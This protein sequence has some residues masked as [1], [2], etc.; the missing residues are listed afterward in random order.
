MIHLRL[1]TEYS[2]R[3]AYGRPA[4]VL[5]ALD[6]DERAAA[7]IG[8][9]GTWGHVA[10]WKACRKAEVKPL[11]G[12]EVLVVPDPELRGKEGRQTGPM[13]ALLARNATG[14]REL[15]RTMTWAHNQGFF[16][17]PRLSYD[18]INRLSTG[19]IIVLSGHNA[20]IGA[21]DRQRG[22]IWLEMNPSNRAWNRRVQ[23]AGGGWGKVICANNFYPTARTH[24]A[25]EIIA[26][27]NRRSRISGAH[28]PSRHELALAVPEAGPEEYEATRHIA[29]LIRLRG[30][31]Q[32][33]MVTHDWPESLEAMCRQGIARRG[34]DGDRWTDEY[35][36]RMMREVN[37][38]EEQDFADYFQVITDM[39][40]EA[41]RTMFVGP[42][43]GSAAGSLVCYLL[44]I[45]DVDPLVH[46]L[47]FERFIDV[48][49]SDLPDIDI[50][51]PDRKRERVIAQL[52]ERWGE[53]HVGRIGTVSRYK[54]RS[55]LDD[56]ARELRIPKWE[57]EDVKGTI[58]ERSSGDERAAFAVADALGDTE[59]GKGLL[60]KYPGI[61][62]AGT[63]EGHARHS[64]M[65]AAGVLVTSKP[66]TAFASIDR[67]GASQIDKKDAEALGMLKLD[68][69][70]LRTL[71]V[72][73]DALEQIGK[74]VEWLITYPL[75]DED[76]FEVLNA[77]HY[78]GIFQFEGYALQTLCRQM[79]IREFSDIASITAL[80]R[81]GPL[82]C[83]AANEFVQR[84]LGKAKIQH[85]HP[86][87]SHAA[88]D[89]YGTVIY[90]EQVMKVC[91][92]MGK[93][94]WK[95][96]TMIRRIM[97]KSF[98]DEFFARY[99]E[100][101]LRGA[102]EQGVDPVVAKKVWDNICT[103]GSWAFNKSHAVS[104]GLISYWCCLLKAHWP[105]EFGAACL[106]NAKDNDQGL[107]ILRELLEEGYEYLPV[108][109][110]HSG[111]TW[112]VHDGK[113]IGGL[114]NIK[115]IGPK[116]AEDIMRRREG[117]KPIPPGM[118]KLL[119]NPVTPFDHVF[120][121][122]ERFGDIYDNPEAH[123]I[124][125]GGVSR[126]T[127]IHEPGEYVFIGRLVER[128]LRDMNEAHSLAKRGGR[129]VRGRTRFLNLVLEDDTGQIL[130][131][132]VR[133]LYPRL[134]VPIVEQMRTGD[135]CLFKGYIRGNFRLVFI[136]Q[137]RYLEEKEETDK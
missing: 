102:T 85:I 31:P 26:G 4:E 132:I 47:M 75:D 45:T 21:L 71:S 56:V 135:Y 70:G 98:G 3:R 124:L 91:R 109:V 133:G 67:N 86:I 119:L 104:Y 83:G 126:I 12:V 13:M 88:A 130:G 51:F 55:A 1:R 121:A 65:H 97:S 105:L 18:H 128:K 57:V 68:L 107:K 74:G 80:A 114:T 37:L 63:I 100:K 60:R 6:E 92:D 10:W 27:R 44:D 108:D 125:S 19:N 20:D 106:R 7:G 43:R 22:N 49:R 96:V 64:G 23:R 16:Y 137:W 66:L 99:W 39:V 61:R 38:I 41:K 42:A 72:L 25:Y 81:P 5:G 11:L 87:L 29:G 14:L 53:D 134:G 90:Q 73:E 76:A 84:R 50:D 32:A 36:A 127:D 34:L 79:K 35:E 30:L 112:E 131:K 115:G 52:R 116:K 101:F 54:P 17:V 129:R 77:E 78:A 93:F 120:E 103:F 9:D 95:D 122:Q 40:R 117:D 111:L 69:L 62:L 33:S 89:S 136:T 113:L 24:E 123:K 8:D 15:Y 58:T 46:D 28:I 94:S 59:I 118:L 48:T 82:H 2:F 110:D